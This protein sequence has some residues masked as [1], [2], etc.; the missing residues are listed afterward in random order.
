[1]NTIHIRKTRLGELLVQRGFMSEMQLAQ[2][3]DHQKAQT[4]QKPVGE[5]CVELRIHYQRGFA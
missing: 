2:A 4:P 3:L 5:T 1:M